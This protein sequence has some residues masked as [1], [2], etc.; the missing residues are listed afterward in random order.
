MKPDN[1]YTLSYIR[2]HP[3]EAARSLERLPAEAG[4]ALFEAL[5]AEVTAPL[6]ACMSP[7]AAA[8]C[9]A[10]MAP[11][12]AADL[13]QRLRA[14]AAALILS[15][16]PSEPAGEL[17]RRFSTTARLRV[18]RLLNRHPDTVGAV[19]SPTA[20]A[21]PAAL[22]VTD[23]IRRIQQQR[24]GPVCDIYLVDDAHRL[25]GVVNTAALL[26]AGGRRPLRSLAER[27][28]ATLHAST[29]LS[30]ALNHPA[31]RGHRI[32]PV[33]ENDGTLI[34]T[35]DRQ[36]LLDATEHSRGPAREDPLDTTLELVNLYWIALAE[37]VRMMAGPGDDRRQE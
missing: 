2:A 10:R 36:S 7:P 31:W 14:A 26:K 22:T 34:G 8:A 18:R 17:L 30:T 6:L 11:A 23:A 19:M 5:D 3:A 37:T 1:R 28:D 12:R 4:G 21:L 16:M 13:L 27:E 35:L 9:L 20:P 15:A 29:A 25:V 24:S 32:L 33:T